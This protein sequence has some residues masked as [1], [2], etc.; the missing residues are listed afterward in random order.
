[1]L[2][3]AQTPEHQQLLGGLQEIAASRKQSIAQL[4]LAWNLRL[5]QTTSVLI[6]ASSPEQIADA[7]ATCDNL[8][9]S[10]EELTAIDQLVIAA[11]S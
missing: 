3:L 2:A 5:P 7:I 6:G 9:F 11:S 8:S 4:A 1:M 10:S